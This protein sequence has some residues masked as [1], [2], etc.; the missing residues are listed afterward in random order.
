METP[1]CS[2]FIH[3]A[4]LDIAKAYDSVEHT[5]LNFAMRSLGVPEGILSLLLDIDK[6]CSVVTR[7][8]HGL[9]PEAP[10]GRGAR[11][12][13]PLSCIRFNAF[14]NG[15]LRHLDT[16]QV[17]WSLD[18]KNKICAQL[19]ADDS[20]LAAG[21]KSDLQTLLSLTHQF[22]SFFKIK[23]NYGKSYY[24]TNDPKS[25]G[26]V[27][28]RER[29]NSDDVSQPLT[30]V[31]PTHPVRYLG[32]KITLTLDWSY[33]IK[34][35]SDKLSLSA[36]II[37]QAGVTSHDAITAINS[38]LIGRLNYLF[39]VIT[40]PPAK[41]KEWDQILL[42]AVRTKVKLGK[43]QPLIQIFASTQDGG[44]GLR[45]PSSIYAQITV[46]DAHAR[47]SDDSLL[48]TLTWERLTAF[49][50]KSAF[51]S[52]ALRTPL[53]A[54]YAKKSFSTNHMHHVNHS[55][56]ALGWSLDTDKICLRD[57]P[58]LPHDVEIMTQ[59]S[60]SHRVQY[61]PQLAARNLFYLSEIST[62]DRKELVPWHTLR[63]RL[64]RKPTNPPHWYL[65]LQKLFT[66]SPDPTQLTLLPKYTPPEKDQVIWPKPFEDQKSRYG[67]RREPDALADEE[68][69]ISRLN[70][71]NTNV[72]IP[73]VWVS[74]GSGRHLPQ[75]PEILS[76]GCSLLPAQNAYTSLRR[77]R[78][79]GKQSVYKSELLALV[80]AAENATTES[81]VYCLLDNQ[82]VVLG[83]RKPPKTVRAR[84]KRPA[85]GLWN[86]FFA[87]IRNRPK[88]C[89]L[90]AVWIR[91]HTEHKTLIHELHN[92]CDKMAGEA[93]ELPNVELPHFPLHEETVVVYD[94]LGNI[95]EDN[96]RKAA[97]RRWLD[98]AYKSKEI[99]GKP[100]LF[101]SIITAARETRPTQRAWETI[102]KG[103]YDK[104]L[105]TFLQQA[106][107]NRI[108]T[109]ANLGRFLPH[110]IE[111]ANCPHCEDTLDTF[112]HRMLT[113][114]H[115]LPLAQSIR[116][117]LAAL[118]AKSSGH[119]WSTI[120]PPD[121]PNLRALL[122]A[123]WPE[124]IRMQYTS[125]PPKNPLNLGDPF[126]KEHGIIK[127]NDD[128][129]GTIDVGFF[130]NGT[131]SQ[132]K[133][134]KLSAFLTNPIKSPKRPHTLSVSFKYTL[135]SRAGTL[136]TRP[137]RLYYRFGVSPHSGIDI[138][139]YT[140]P[141]N[142]P[143]TR[144]M[145]TSSSSLTR[146][147]KERPGLKNPRN[148]TP[149]RPEHAPHGRPRPRFW[150]Y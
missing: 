48:S 71:P 92:A 53:V 137:C 89:P 131:R 126:D 102:N 114:P 6:G 44:L 115:R 98:V 103:Y 78:V 22:F 133:K 100:S 14:M 81:P 35:I 120:A 68:P 31:P 142:K 104:P 5:A 7:T 72:V 129:D 4:Y 139:R 34:D 119:P 117:S 112:A 99:S 39:Q 57:P 148:S 29:D 12:G 85:R 33:H 95:V 50:T 23:A 94:H 136:S 60:L 116:Q 65:C 66:G 26:T 16:A 146:K 123:F 138:P 21:S 3:V 52:C 17:G 28:L 58:N 84:C 25:E 150:T 18:S 125:P 96:I 109:Y 132:N 83:S 87:A 134:M 144:S 63:E 43:S 32:Y 37:K 141:R 46:N 30:W 106:R 135:N 91:G 79:A 128:R 82:S 74:D 45:L 41:L 130:K 38:V 13:D 86:R 15:L 24:S 93:T 10:L 88:S 143:R 20:F 36:E 67:P 73:Q 76:T 55:L 9:S 118:I 56:A 107:T 90:E 97:A 42:A 111:S 49:T 47:L 2:S 62:P 80:T 64:K 77:M 51:N 147:R 121:V 59:L 124:K 61:G 140:A 1:D 70:Q 101:H 110:L 122:Q 127:S 105:A 149:K 145:T 54:S 19:F 69:A 108:P 113:C 27:Y 40:I 11:Q 8:P 75:S